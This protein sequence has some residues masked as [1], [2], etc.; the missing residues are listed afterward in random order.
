MFSLSLKKGGL[1][2]PI[3]NNTYS[4]KSALFL[5]LLTTR[6]ESPKKIN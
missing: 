6:G 5:G 3:G 2:H 1:A 4:G